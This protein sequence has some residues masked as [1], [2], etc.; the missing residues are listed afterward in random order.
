MQSVSAEAVVIKQAELSHVTRQ[1]QSLKKIIVDN[2]VQSA[3]LQQQL[4][5]AELEIGKLSGQVIHLT[6]AL[7]AQQKILDTLAV[8]QQETQLKLKIQD[9]AL[10][11][12]LR[13]AW[14]LGSQ[15]QLKILLNQESLSAANRH[16]MYYKT[17]NEARAK[18]IMAIQQNLT[19]LQATLKASKAHQQTLKK[20][21]AEKEYQQKRQQRI[22]TL[23]QGLITALGSQTQSK[24]QQIDTLLANQ[25][26]L[27]ETITRL[28]QKEITLTGLPFNQLQR[29]LAWPVKGTFVTSYGSLT[30]GSNQRSYGTVIKAPTGTPVHAIYS[31]RVVFAD[32]LRGFGLLI[33]I[34]HG[35]QY[36][37]LYGRNQA[38]YIKPGQIVRTGDVI[39]ATGNS[40]GY[41][42]SALYFEMRQNGTPINP[43]IWC[44]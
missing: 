25:Q 39:A 21:L 2:Q 29:K 26:A 27:Q 7:A 8:T 44:R 3:N 42:N 31:G 37:S 19:L 32:W 12:Q 5:T 14:Q 24:Q 15:N 23:R 33:I 35:N 6:Q 11:H 36:M 43:A 16:L 9:D 41:N 10:A 17:M 40:G 34:N 38:I 18:L 22:L 4:K 13:A 20:L 30:D 28:K 1:I